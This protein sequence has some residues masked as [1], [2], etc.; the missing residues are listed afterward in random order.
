MLPA[1]VSVTRGPGYTSS[2]AVSPDG[3]TIVIAASDKD[4]QRLVSP[5]ARPSRSDATRRHR[6]RIEPILLVGRRVDRVLRRRSLEADS[7]RRRRV[8]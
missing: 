4:G 2:V 1:G 7:S 6:T 8:G 3:R 5:L